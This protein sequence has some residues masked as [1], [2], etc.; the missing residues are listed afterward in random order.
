MSARE[1]TINQEDSLELEMVDELV[2]E[3][4]EGSIGDIGAVVEILVG[5]VV[6]SG[7]VVGIGKVVAEV[8]AIGAFGS[9]GDNICN[10]SIAADAWFAPSGSRT[11]AIGC[12]SVAKKF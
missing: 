3:L 9:C 6:V 1:P 10:R 11:E 5:V 7:L 8:A 4:G 2:D 12:I